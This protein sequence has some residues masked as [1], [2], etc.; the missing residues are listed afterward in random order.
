M[1]NIAGQGGCYSPRPK[2]EVDK[3]PP[4]RDLQNSLHPMKA[5]FNNFL[6]IHSKHLHFAL[7]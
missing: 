2:A 1:K 3:T 4:P 6:I 7:C 5:E